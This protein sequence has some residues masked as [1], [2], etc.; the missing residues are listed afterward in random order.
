MVHWLI[1]VVLVLIWIELRY[2]YHPVH[3]VHV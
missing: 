1:F 3:A 2:V